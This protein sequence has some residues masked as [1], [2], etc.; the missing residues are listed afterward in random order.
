MDNSTSLN[1]F[2]GTWMYTSIFCVKYSCLS[3]NWVHK[4]VKYFKFL[5]EDAAW[6][7]QITFHKIA[8]MYRHYYTTFPTNL[9]RF[10]FLMYRHY[11]T[12]FPTNL[13]RFFFLCWE[14]VAAD[15]I[16]AGAQCIPLYSGASCQHLHHWRDTVKDTLFPAIFTSLSGFKSFPESRLH[17][18]YIWN[19]S[20]VEVLVKCCYEGSYSCNLRGSW[21][22]YIVELGCIICC[23]YSWW[24]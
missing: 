14:A 15:T 20:H 18:L 24:I 10:F 16:T 5:C 23:L 17:I 21:W 4:D 19:F 12:T 7:F 9:F 11:H 3:S 22:T 1:F 2:F 13:F 8:L 6:K